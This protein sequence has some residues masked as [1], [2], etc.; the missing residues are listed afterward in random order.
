LLLTVSAGALAGQTISVPTAG[1]EVTLPDGYD[2][3]VPAQPLDALLARRMAGQEILGQALIRIESI[4][5]GYRA[6]RF[7]ADDY[8]TMRKNP[9]WDSLKVL[10]RAKLTVAGKEARGRLLRFGAG[11][12]EQYMAQAAFTRELPD[13][14]F[15]LVYL[16]TVNAPASQ[17]ETLVDHLESIC[18]S[19]KLTDFAPIGQGE[20]SMASEPVALPVGMKLQV[21]T[22]W[23][24]M[25]QG[26]RILFGQTEFATGRPGLIQGVLQIGALEPG[27]TLDGQVSMMLEQNASQR[28]TAEEAGQDPAALGALTDAGQVKLGELTARKLVTTYK[29]AGVVRILLI[30][31]E[32]WP[33]APQPLRY[34]LQIEGPL[35]AKQYIES[36]ATKIANATAIT[37]PPQ[38]EQPEQPGQPDATGPVAPDQPDNPLAPEEPQ[39]DNPL[40]PG[41]GAAVPGIEDQP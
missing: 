36:A 13:Q 19:L 35:D 39:P 41:G 37:A 15:D 1:L 8:M 31:V 22:G 14:D 18:D 21:P 26:P 38:P 30:A 29:A 6:D 5:R 24:A 11:E 7:L 4:R 27:A 17:K 20:I 9:A 33:D 25:A 3:G 16:V 10:A 2:L 34:I 23:Y 12:N 28:Q 32:T 40:V